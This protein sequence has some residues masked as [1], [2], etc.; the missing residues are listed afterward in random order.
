M[1]T[2]NL[3]PWRERKRVRASR[4]FVVVFAVALGIVAGLVAVAKRFVDVA[5]TEQAARNTTLTQQL[6]ALDAQVTR[7]EKLRAQQADVSERIQIIG[8]LQEERS[9]VVQV[10]DELVRSLPIEVYLRELERTEEK[11]F[12]EG[13][14]TSYAGITEFMR[15][16]ESSSEFNSANL[17]DIA[18]EES[19]TG[20]ASF[21]FNL[22][23]A[24]AARQGE[25]E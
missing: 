3:L 22:G 5:L 21:V 15:R 16:L 4:R 9:F 12:V 24:L 25:D 17:N 7:V 10:F 1:T 20:P 11:L 18:A 13:V 19:D 2:I 8:Q 6:V 23:I 14:S